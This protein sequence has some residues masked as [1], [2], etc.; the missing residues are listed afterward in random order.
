[1]LSNS[2]GLIDCHTHTSFSIDSTANIREMI[3]RAVALGLRAFSVTDHCE[4]NRWYGKEYYDNPTT[5]LYFNFGQNFEDS[6]AEVTRLKEEYD[7]QIELICGVELGQAHQERDIAQKV[8][9]DPRVDFIIGSVHQ[10][11]G[12]EDF[13]LIDYTG[14]TK[15]TVYALLTRY[16]AE[17][18]ELCRWG[19]F[20]ILGHLTYTLRYMEGNAG[21][22]VDMRKYDDIIDEIL[23]T[24]IAAGKGIEI[25]T[26]GLRQAY[27]DTFPSE[28]YVRRYRELGGE[29]LSLG[30]DSH[31]VADVG[32]GIREGAEIARRAGFRYVTYFKEHT[33]VF[34]PLPE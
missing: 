32:R 1:M 28:R 33:P 15:E 30:S 20:D 18:L 26:S 23:K 19:K 3:D 16:F 29:I 14:Y 10:L 27:G 9:E 31:V 5:Y 12:E 2:K 34:I 22:Q 11:R 24:V 7:G 4:C 25:N 21:I 6:V 8:V 13:A 17:V